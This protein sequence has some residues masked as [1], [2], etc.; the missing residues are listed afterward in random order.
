MVSSLVA[1]LEAVAHRSGS[2]VGMGN[3]GVENL[4]AKKLRDFN[5]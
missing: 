3:A 5:F 1:Q 4:E 2:A